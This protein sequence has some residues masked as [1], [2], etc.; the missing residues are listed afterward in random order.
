MA[1]AEK[2]V[3]TKLFLA[4]RQMGC[5]SSFLG[6]P[7]RERGLRLCLWLFAWIPLLVP[8]FKAKSAALIVFCPP[9]PGL[10]YVDLLFDK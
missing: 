4:L 1:L 3:D 2:Q 7:K 9:E 10:A 6:H 5:V 8:S